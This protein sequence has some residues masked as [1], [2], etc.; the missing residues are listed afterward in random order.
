MIVWL[1][2]VSKTRKCICQERILQQKERKKYLEAKKNKATRYIDCLITSSTQ[3]LHLFSKVTFYVHS[4]ETFRICVE[5]DPLKSLL[6]F[7]EFFNIL[8]C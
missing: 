1:C 5:N 2:E 7:R 8:E 4:R 6:N 3:K